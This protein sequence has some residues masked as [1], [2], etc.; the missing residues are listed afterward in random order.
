MYTCIGTHCC[1]AGNIPASPLVQNCLMHPQSRRGPPP[2][3]PLGALL[4]FARGLHAVHGYSSRPS[5]EWH[6]S[7]WKTHTHVFLP[8]YRKSAFCASFLQN[9]ITRPPPPPGKGQFG[10][11][12]V[13]LQILLNLLCV[14]LYSVEL[15]KKACTEL[16]NGIEI[17][18]LVTPCLTTIPGGPKETAHIRFCCWHTHEHR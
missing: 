15:L 7:L 6:P 11:C 16:Q 2:P 13:G 14:C 18:I 1:H 9:H 17:K 4:Q 5:T 3:H 12:C 8:L 10:C